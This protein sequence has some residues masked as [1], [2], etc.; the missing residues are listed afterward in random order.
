MKKVGQLSLL[1][2]IDK[3]NLIDKDTQKY[4]IGGG[5]GTPDDPFT[6]E[7]YNYLFYSGQWQGGCV[8]GMGWVT[9]D[10]YIYAEKPGG[11]GSY[12]KPGSG[13]SG[14]SGGSLWPGWPGGGSAGSYPG[15]NNYYPNH[16]DYP[17]HNNY[18]KPYSYYGYYG[19]HSSGGGGGSW[20]GSG[21]EEHGKDWDFIKVDDGECIVGSI[22]NA[23]KML[24]VNLKES[25]ITSDLSDYKNDN[26]NRYFVSDEK[27]EDILDDYFNVKVSKKVGDITKHVSSGKPV[28]IR[29]VER[30]SDLNEDIQLQELHDVIITSINNVEG[31]FE[32]YDPVKGVTRRLSETDLRSNKVIKS[33]YLLDSK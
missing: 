33:Y 31:Y 19:Y 32:Y 30:E 11:Y 8:E 9:P 15:H 13:G 23:G 17:G 14:G 25:G 5:S 18:S 20:G 29:L 16:N 2:L 28:Y 4:L 22:V 26:I 1:N 10:V 12:T 21:D 27:L 6:E 7:E 3:C 24:G